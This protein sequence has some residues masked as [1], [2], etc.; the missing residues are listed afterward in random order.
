MAVAR[1]L[2]EHRTAAWQEAAMT[3]RS[4]AAGGFFLILAIFIGFGWGVATGH[5]VEGVLIG[6]LVGVAFA[7]LVWLADRRKG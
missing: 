2:L 5:P 6:T 7:V 3:R 1:L 4:P